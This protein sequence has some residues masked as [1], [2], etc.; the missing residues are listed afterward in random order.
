[1]DVSLDLFKYTVS[2]SRIGFDVQTSGYLVWQRQYLKQLP[3]VSKSHFVK[4]LYLLHLTDD[5]YFQ[6]FGNN[7]FSV[8]LVNNRNILAIFIYDPQ[9]RVKLSLNMLLHC[10]EQNDSSN[11]SNCVSVKSYFIE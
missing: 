1:M 9:R 10:L 8:C 11:V 3:H 5:V 2:L 6:T 4:Q 7:F